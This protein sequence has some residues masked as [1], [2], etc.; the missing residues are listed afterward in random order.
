[1]LLIIVALVL[2]FIMIKVFIEPA[3]SEYTRTR[4]LLKKGQLT[5]GPIIGYNQKEDLDQRL[6]YAPV[7]RLT[8]PDGK[9]YIIESNDY[10]FLQKD[11]GTLVTICYE[12]EY[13][14]DAIINPRSIIR[15]QMFLMVFIHVVMLG[16]TIGA[17]FFQAQD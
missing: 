16:I 6:Q 1:M 14:E 12:V 8:T 2:D 3:W 13:P 5:K 9:E 11:I 10:R 4:Q 17:I 15:T 7:A